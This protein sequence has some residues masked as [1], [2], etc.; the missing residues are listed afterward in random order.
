MARVSL[1]RI[2]SLRSRMLRLVKIIL[3]GNCIDVWCL[4]AFL[5]G[6]GM[7]ETILY[8]HMVMDLDGYF[9]H[10]LKNAFDYYC[11]MNRYVQYF[12]HPHLTR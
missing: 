11:T 3:Q 6:Q 10:C 2:G 5:D 1:G 9:K 8:Y 4:L 12:L 7:R